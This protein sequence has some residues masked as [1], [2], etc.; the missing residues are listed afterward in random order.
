MVRQAGYFRDYEYK[1]HGTLSLLAS[2]NLHSSHVFALVRERHQSCEF[3]ELLK[4]VDTYY[5]KNWRIRLI[6]DNHF[7]HTSKE[8]QKF[9]GPSLT[10]LRLSLVK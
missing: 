9:L 8:T 1:R 4:E 2:L 5:P 6:L 3:I 10:S 7:F